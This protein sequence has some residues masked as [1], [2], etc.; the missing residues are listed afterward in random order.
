MAELGDGIVCSS[1][2]AELVRNGC[3]L[4]A[5][6]KQD[7]VGSASVAITL[8]FER[9]KSFFFVNLEKWEILGVHKGRDMIR[10]TIELEYRR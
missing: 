3:Y 6:T 9:Q 7:D 2:V 8:P 1:K 4:L 10:I 5:T